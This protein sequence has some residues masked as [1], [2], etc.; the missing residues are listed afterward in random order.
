MRSISDGGISRW[1]SAPVLERSNVQ[2][3]EAM[4]FH[5]RARIF[6]HCCA[7]GRAHSEIPT[8]ALT[9]PTQRPRRRL[10][11][12][13]DQIKLRLQLQLEILKPHL[14]RP[15]GVDLQAN[16]ATTRDLRIIEVNA[17]VTV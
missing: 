1:R 16:D 17:D 4:R 7:R 14:H 10:L 8:H 11:F 9:A 13:S 3:Y 2:I 15:A 6:R 12:G 5:G